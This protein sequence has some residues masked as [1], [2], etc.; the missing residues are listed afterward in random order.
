MELS[1][2]IPSQAMQM[3]GNAKGVEPILLARIRSGGGKFVCCL[4]SVCTSLKRERK[5]ESKKDTKSTMLSEMV[6][7]VTVKQSHNASQ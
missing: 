6:T 2:E 1:L 5:G 7:Y 3:T 4:L